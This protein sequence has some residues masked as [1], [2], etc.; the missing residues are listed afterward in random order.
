MSSRL[1][2]RSI[3]A[4]ALTKLTMDAGYLIADPSAKVRD[5]FRLAPNN[6]I[7]DLL[8]Q[9]REDLQGIE[10]RGEPERVCQFLTFLQEKLLDP[11]LLE[12]TATEEDEACVRASIEFPG[13]AKEFLDEIRFSMTPTISKHHRM[14]IVDSKAL[15]HAED[16]LWRDPS[17]K[18]SIEQ[19]LFREAILLPLEKAGVVKLEHMRP[20]GKAMRPREGL[21]LDL[22]EHRIVFRRSFLA[23]GKYDGLDLPIGHGDYGLTE[24]SEGSWVVKHSYHTREGK[25]IGEY[26][27]INTPVELYPYGARYLDLE[28]DVIKRSG[29][30]PFVIDREKLQLLCRQGVIGSALESQVN[31][32]VDTLMQRLQA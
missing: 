13:A 4:T 28:V 20:S 15:D 7:H 26:F 31:H 27:N 25:L 16:R 22:N 11:V 32:V 30:S 24:I 29:E 17:R 23:Q 5:R 1:K 14:R 10:V 2:I 8:I 21:L 3:Y 6:E 19:E 12:L 18:E 9:D